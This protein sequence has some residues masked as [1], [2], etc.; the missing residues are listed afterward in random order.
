[1]S[2]KTVHTTPFHLWTLASM[3]RAILRV[4]GGTKGSFRVQCAPGG[5]DDPKNKQVPGEAKRCTFCVGPRSLAVVHLHGEQPPGDVH[6][7]GVVEVRLELLRLE[8]GRSRAAPRGRVGKRTASD[9]HCL[10]RDDAADQHHAARATT[11]PPKTLGHTKRCF[12]HMDLPWAG[13]GKN[14]KVLSVEKVT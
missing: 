14:C 13:V 7:R 5:G 8:R 4:L 10:A 3:R 1:M 12:R 9:A 6:Q 2:N 11:S